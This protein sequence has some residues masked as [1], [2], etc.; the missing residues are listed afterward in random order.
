[1]SHKD[2]LTDIQKHHLTAFTV[3][4]AMLMELP[5]EEEINATTI[6]PS[7]QLRMDQ[8]LSDYERKQ[9]TSQVK[10]HFTKIAACILLFTV[11]PLSVAMSVEASREMII[12]F[13]GGYFSISEQQE[14]PRRDF[15]PNLP[16]K[17]YKNIYLP[18]WMPE[19]YIITEWTNLTDPMTIMYTGDRSRI[20]F[21]QSS[22]NLIQYEDS[23][24][25][26]LNMYKVGDQ[27]YFYGN[28]EN[29]DEFLHKLLWQKDGVYFSLEG[30]ED[31][32]I[33]FKIAESIK[34]KGN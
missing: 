7:L 21:F 27:T 5:S 1:M 30:S 13:F 11:L 34:W 26:D 15:D 12:K 25:K 9:K 2:N 22:T 33:L 29:S 19:G 28:K 4:Q 31:Q 3:N 18:E 16:L 32:G 14:P 6:P 20:R 24:I 17:D 23:D 10:K 8:L